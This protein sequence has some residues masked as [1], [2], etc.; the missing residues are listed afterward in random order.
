MQT[1]HCLEHLKE[2]H[3]HQIKQFPKPCSIFGRIYVYLEISKLTC[4]LYTVVPSITVCRLPGLIWFGL[5]LF[6]TFSFDLTI[7]CLEMTHPCML[8]FVACKTNS[9]HSFV[10]FLQESF[11]HYLFGITEPDC[12][13][14]VD[15][16]TARCTIF[17]PRLPDV[18]A[19]W[20]GRF[21]QKS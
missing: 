18:Y 9:D 5:I 6:Q 7:N 17:M 8:I 4:A 10:V 2:W 14:A 3:R 1:Y 21:V 15:V 19:V 11:F 20:M 13:G 16:D 12:Y